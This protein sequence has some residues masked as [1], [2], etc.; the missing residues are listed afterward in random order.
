MIFDEEYKKLKGKKKQV[1][2]LMLKSNCKNQQDIADTLGITQ[3]YV[4]RILNE[5]KKAISKD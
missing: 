4:S 2:D 5:F 3:N 1:I